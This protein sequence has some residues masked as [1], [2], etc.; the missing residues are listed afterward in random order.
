MKSDP[1]ATTPFSL[2]DS[3]SRGERFRILRPHAK[4]GLGEVHVARDEELNREVALKKIQSV[5]ADR[6]ESRS[7]F[8]P[9][10][11]QKRSCR[12]NGGVAW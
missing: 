6:P 8:E 1:D 5:H 3:S 4:G 9:A 11:L 2:G 12:K 10:P 7:R